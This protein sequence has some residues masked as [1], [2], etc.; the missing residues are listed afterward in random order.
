MSWTVPAGLVDTVPPSSTGI[1]RQELSAST[2]TRRLW[3]L[4]LDLCEDSESVPLSATAGSAGG[5]NSSKRW[6]WDQQKVCS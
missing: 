1:R 5:M 2:V 6:G 4:R 3:K